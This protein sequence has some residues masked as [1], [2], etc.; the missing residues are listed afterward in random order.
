MALSF[1]TARKLWMGLIALLS[2]ACIFL[3]VSLWSHGYSRSNNFGALI[4]IPCFAC[5]GAIWTKK[6][7]SPQIV[8]VEVTWVFALLPFQILLGL[9]AFE[10]DGA[11]GSR[12]FAVYEALVVLIWTNSVLVFLYVAGIVSL[13]LLTQ[14][15]CDQE[16]WAR[17][18]DSSPCPFPFPVLLVYAFPFTARYFHGAV[19]E[20]RGAPA[21]TTDFCLPGCSCHTKPTEG[22]GLGAEHANYLEG[23][24]SSIPIRVPTA[25][26]RYNAIRVTL[27][28]VAR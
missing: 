21:T 10:S 24:Q 3:A 7:F 15:S 18:I 12:F 4:V 2:L 14:F 23:T 28:H 5:A 20:S 25:M 22:P 11:L 6:F 27:G 8:C 16:V 9:F 17:D 19:A 1:R 26:E 13:A